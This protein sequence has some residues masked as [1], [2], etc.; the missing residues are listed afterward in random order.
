MV[1]IV[2][3]LVGA[4]L[5]P[6]VSTALTPFMN[7]VRQYF[8]EMYP[9]ET[10]P[11]QTLMQM[12]L[13]Q[14]IPQNVYENE[15]KRNGIDNELA[16]LAL[17]S[18]KNWVGA[19]D[20]ITLWRREK[21][22][23]SD[24]DERLSRLAYSPTQ[25]VFL[26]QVTEFFP[27]A[28][29]LILW[30]VREVYSPDLRSKYGLDADF[31]PEFSQEA[32]KI[33]INED[34]AKNYWAAH[35][36]LPGIRD[37]FEMFHR[38]QIQEDN[39][40]EILR[41]KDIMPYFREPL[42]NIAYNPL[43]RVDVRRMHN[44]DVLSDEQVKEAYQHLGYSPENAQ[45]MLDFTI[46]YNSDEA[47]G[48]SRAVIMSAYDKN[49]I[50]EEQLKIYLTE[51][52]YGESIVE[53]WLSMAAYD[54]EQAK[55]MADVDSI[56]SQVRMCQIEKEDGNYQLLALGQPATF[57]QSII[58]EIEREEKERVRLPTKTDLLRWLDQQ[59]ISESD[60]NSTMRKIGY[61]SGD[62][63]LYLTEAALKN[64]GIERKYLGIKTYQ[65]WLSLEIIDIT[66][67]R[68]IAKDMNISDEDIG[69]LIDETQ[70]EEKTE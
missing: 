9:N 21:I 5:L 11:L 4:M 23:E 46:E 45:R 1:N 12:R 65:K 27:Q 70:E 37:A 62:I 42:K 20:L 53:F 50:N 26:K 60:F 58:E 44:L 51:M 17:N 3:G 68:Q 55:L 56:K 22:E 33:G 47:K 28:Q 43:T 7:M 24:L 63:R 52:G 59:V 64:E 30:A 41:A 32:K 36:E 57:T 34:M 8:Y 29:D 13:R 38:G 2:G 66:V 40:M 6:A 15:A 35:W 16:I 19:V 69:R 54:K 18:Q 49:L 67:F 39:L 10:L 31:P 25:I 48:L 61:R 14:V